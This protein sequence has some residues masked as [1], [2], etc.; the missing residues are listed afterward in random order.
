MFNLPHVASRVFGTPLMIAR[1]KLEV[2]LGV[3]AHRLSSVADL[4]P[5]AEREDTTPSRWMRKIA[6]DKER[7]KSLGL[8]FGPV[9]G[10]AMVPD[11]STA[12]DHDDL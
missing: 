4:D 7:E 5:L 9:P 12:T 8:T 11:T 3:L 1:A 6:A 2:I 10:A